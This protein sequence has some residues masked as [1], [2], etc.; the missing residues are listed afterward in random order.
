MMRAIFK[1]YLNSLIRRF[2]LARLYEVK[3]LLEPH[4]ALHKAF[5]SLF[6]FYPG[7][8]LYFERRAEERIVFPHQPKTLEMASKEAQRLYHILQHTGH[9]AHRH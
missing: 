4:S 2:G 8:L 3:C 1:R 9:H 7:A 6:T 5:L